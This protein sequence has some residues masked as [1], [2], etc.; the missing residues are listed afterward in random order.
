MPDLLLVSSS[1]RLHSFE[2]SESLLDLGENSR[3]TN[4]I[5][6]R[7][8][9]GPGRGLQLLQLIAGELKALA[10]R[11]EVE[12]LS[13]GNLKQGRVSIVF[14][15]LWARL[16]LRS[17]MKRC[18]LKL[19]GFDRSSHLP[20]GVLTSILAILSWLRDRTLLH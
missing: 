11:A 7:L 2:N 17:R 14:N 9:I 13:E 5:V 18:T 12:H 1:F 6:G 20:R 8:A 19:R 16:D 15:W 4:L 3:N 10:E